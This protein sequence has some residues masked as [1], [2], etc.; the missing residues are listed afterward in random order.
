MEEDYV[1]LQK[2]S[3]KKASKNLWKQ[4][5]QNHAKKSIK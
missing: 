5:T 3:F 1:S 2:S 4:L